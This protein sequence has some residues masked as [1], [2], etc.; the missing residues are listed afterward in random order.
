MVRIRRVPIQPY[1]ASIGQYSTP[2]TRIGIVQ[3]LLRILCN[4][5]FL[6]CDHLH[7]FSK[8][9]SRNKSNNAIL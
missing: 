4:R 5:C 3:I 9:I 2:D 6:C 7:T 8:K 1:T